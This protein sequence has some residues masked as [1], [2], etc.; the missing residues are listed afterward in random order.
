MLRTII[1]TV[2]LATVG[3]AVIIAPANGSD[4]AGQYIDDATIGTKTKVALISNQMV[5]ALETN[6]EVYKG[7]VQ[8]SGFVDSEAEEAAAPAAVA[9]SLKAVFEF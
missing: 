1:N 9:R 3:S 7:V 4:T 6:V 8:L 5:S 2:L